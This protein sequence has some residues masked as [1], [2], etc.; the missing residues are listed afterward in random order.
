MKWI[1]GLA[2]AAALCG[3]SPGGAEELKKL[4]A[5]L[6]PSKAYVVVE[7][8]SLDDTKIA[9]NLMLARYDA[10]RGDVFGLG[11]AKPAEGEAPRPRREH[12]AKGMVKDKARGTR[13]HLLELDPALYVVEAANGTSFSLGS[14]TF[15]AEAGTV[16]DLGVMD[17]ITDWPE[18]EGPAKIGVKDILKMGLLGGFAGPKQDPR[19][20]FVTVRERAAGD[21]A[22]PASLAKRV[23]PVAWESRD[24]IFGNHLG[25]MINR[26]GGRAERVV[27]KAQ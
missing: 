20:V 15:R 18:G 24:S 2:T 23:S 8:G 1:S 4:P 3:A 9:G 7:L 10:E 14:R 6:N 16:V 19:P 17:V 12:A 25:G 11:K 5:E 13:L 27:R 26:F 22:L 21:M